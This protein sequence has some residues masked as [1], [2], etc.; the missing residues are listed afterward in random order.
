MSFP[1]AQFMYMD[2]VG[3]ADDAM[4]I[5]LARFVKQKANLSYEI[6]DLHLE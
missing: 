1:N 3:N 4:T 5:C 2:D 6:I